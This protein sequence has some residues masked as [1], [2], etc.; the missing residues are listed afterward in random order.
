MISRETAAKKFKLSILAP[1]ALYL[2]IL[3][4]LGFAEGFALFRMPTIQGAQDVHV[5]GLSR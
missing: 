1:K 4:T 3:N 2:S 5:L